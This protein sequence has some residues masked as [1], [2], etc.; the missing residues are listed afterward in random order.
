MF[1]LA[2]KD[3]Y[4]ATNSLLLDAVLV[5]RAY[6]E[7]DGDAHPL[8]DSMDELE[9]GQ[10]SIDSRLSDFEAFSVEM[11]A[12]KGVIIV[13]A[14]S[15]K[16][17]AADLESK[18]SE[19]ALLY[20]Q[21]ADLRSFAHGRHIWLSKRPQECAVLAITD[22]ALAGLWTQMCANLPA[23]IATFTLELSGSKP[24]DLIAGLVAQMKMIGLIAKTQAQDPAKPYVPE[25]GRALYY[26]DLASN[27]PSESTPEVRGLQP[28]YESMGVRWPSKGTSGSTRRALLDCELAFQE[29]SFRA[30]VFDYDGTLRRSNHP[31]E[32]PTDLMIERLEA[33]IDSGIVVGI[34]SG[35]GE[36][37]QSKLREKINE[38]FWDR[39][40]VGLFNGGWLGT[41]NSE[42]IP[43]ETNNEFLSHVTRILR[44]LQSSGVPIR[45]IKPNYPYQISVRF[46]EGVQAE[47]MWFVIADG[48]RQAGLNSSTVFRSKHSVDIVSPN[49]SK[50][51]L[52]ASIIRKHNIDPYQ[53]VTMGDQG[54]W[55]GND[56]SL[57]EHKFS[58]S[59]DEPSRRLDRGWKLAPDSRRDVDATMWYL[60]RMNIEDGQ[61]CFQLL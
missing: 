12:R 52:I 18:L 31:E 8:P 60:E 47:G 41:L 28:K 2:E 46:H 40:E 48:L 33:I 54:S 9:I 10:E 13:Y 27:V 23:D 14:P 59:V 45:E 39:I 29:Q 1:E 55:P 11:T 4:L 6:S 15:L 26:L 35:R 22:P 57:L 21:I 17:V 36:G 50:T 24:R 61:F 53:I 7:L 34:A 25:F 56:C 32:A 43:E 38:R 20:S 16:A 42:Y 49:I 58:L 51:H 19:S 5:A 44:A 3:G 30:I 37:I